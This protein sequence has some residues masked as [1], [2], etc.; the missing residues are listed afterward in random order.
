MNSIELRFETPWLLLL[1]IPALA[2][3]LLPYFRMPKKRRKLPSR[4]I[5]MIIHCVLAVLMVILLSGFSV[6]R[7]TE[8]QTV[9]LLVD[10]SDSTERIR[11]TVDERAVELEDQLSEHA[12]V[13]TVVFGGDYAEKLDGALTAADAT[14]ISTALEYAASILPDDRVGRIVLVSDGRQTD[15]DA[16]ATAQYLQSQGVRIDTVWVDSSVTGREVQISGFTAPPTAFV[17]QTVTLTATIESN[18]KSTM[19][20]TVQ[21]GDK[22]VYNRQLTVDDT[23]TVL[24]IEVPVEETGTHEY[25]L[26][27]KADQ[28]TIVQ[29]STAVTTVEAVEK[30]HVLL[31]KGVN[32]NYEGLQK[33]LESRFEVTVCDATETPRKLTELCNYDGVILMDAHADDM[34]KSFGGLLNTYVSVYGRSL[35]ALGGTETYMYGAMRNTIYEEIMPLSFNLSRSSDDD[36]VALMLVVDCSLSMSQQSTYMSVAKQ[37]SIKCVEGMTENDYVGIISFNQEATVEAPLGINT[38]AHKE[39]LNRII[40]GLTTSKGTYY[41]DALNLAHQEL[42]KSDAKIR[43]ILFVSDGGPADTEYKELFPAITADG[44]TVSTIALGHEST[45]LSEMANSC[46]GTYYFVQESTELPN[47]MLSLTQQVTV[48]SLMTGEFSPKIAKDNTWTLPAELPQVNGYL[49]TTLKRGAEAHIT[50]E[51]DHP[52][53]ASWTWGNGKVVCFTSN[54]EN[55]W[56]AD[57]LK[58]SGLVT[59]ILLQAMP[60]IHSESSL[61]ITTIPGVKTV[62]VDVRTADTENYMVSVESGDY[63]GQLVAVSPGLYRGTLPVDGIGSYGLCVTQSDMKGNLLDTL[64]CYV[65]VPIKKEYD[66][67]SDDGSALM[68]T[69]SVNGGGILTANA[70]ELAEVTTEPIST[71]SDFR[72]LFGIICALLLLLDIGIR[73]LRWKDLKNLWLTA[74]RRK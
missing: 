46:G 12:S 19:V 21:E 56:C 23:G 14:D 32:A 10:H 51:E 44:I 35:V 54:M 68:K 29:N 53:L 27:L 66:V 5:P 70:K 24:A 63:T 69:V 3:I 48:N 59:D 13:Q 36:S 31:V 62:Q 4:T 64:S 50:L 49:G 60:V 65:N 6:V 33:L 74:I 30:P 8:N 16:A 42:K 37:G 26:V 1:L 71:V 18:S 7:S 11:T 57:W 41:T 72:I 2:L 15:G 25:L 58:E 43:H 52:L 39:S 40:S 17:G 45:V 61:Q 34:P 28:D 67:F 55:D 38:K 47:I 73:K 22:E 9:I 20:V